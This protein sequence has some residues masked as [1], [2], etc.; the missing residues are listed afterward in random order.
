MIDA[1][2]VDTRL[3]PACRRVASADPVPGASGSAATPSQ[4]ERTASVSADQDDDND[5]TGVSASA[6]AGNAPTVGGSP[7]GIGGDIPVFVDHLTYSDDELAIYE[8]MPLEQALRTP[9]NSDAA[10][11]PELPDDNTMVTQIAEEYGH[12]VWGHEYSKSAFAEVFRAKHGYDCDFETAKK[13]ASDN[14]AGEVDSRLIGSVRDMNL[15]DMTEEAMLLEDSDDLPDMTE[16]AVLIE[17]APA[18]EKVIELDESDMELLHPAVFKYSR[19]QIESMRNAVVDSYVRGSV[20]E[21]MLDCAMGLYGLDGISHEEVKEIGMMVLNRE[22]NPR[23]ADYAARSQN[24]YREAEPYDIDITV[25]EPKTETELALDRIMAFEKTRPAP[26]QQ[27]AAKA[28]ASRFDNIPFIADRDVYLLDKDGNRIDN[29]GCIVIED[30][31]IQPLE[32]EVRLYK[33]A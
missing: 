33:A 22:M 18:A 32:E 24:V 9:L 16:H 15:P 3:V 19:Q 17:N 13:I 28:P 6:N 14:Y 2:G 25:E 20:D 27:Y 26:A 11:Q 31:D 30:D 23:D 10:Q 8:E 1:S 12:C 7:S 4:S 21:F 5:S 29:D